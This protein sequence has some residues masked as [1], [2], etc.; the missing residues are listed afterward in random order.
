LALGLVLAAGCG[1]KKHAS[2]N[3]T[4]IAAVPAPTP[5]PTPPPTPAAGPPPPVNVE[6]RN[7]PPEPPKP[8]PEAQAPAVAKRTNPPP[9][10][11]PAPEESQRVSAPP[12]PSLP[13]PGQLS[14]ALSRDD[15][16]ERR[17]AITQLLDGAETNLKNLNRA[18]S[19]DD[20]AVLQHIRSYIK[21]A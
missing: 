18:L 1:G 16:M 9:S 8:Q 6:P 5:S 11:A 4:V 3:P 2:V 10:P 19:N 13:V 21:Q 15:L 20:K 7:V 17:S 14:A 12:G